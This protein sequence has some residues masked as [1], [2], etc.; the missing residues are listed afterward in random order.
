MKNK[1]FLHLSLFLLLPLTTHCMKRSHGQITTYSS[2]TALATPSIIK[3]TTI[4]ELQAKHDK[5]KEHLNLFY[6]PVNLHTNFTRA[7]SDLD[8][9]LCTY[10][11]DLHKRTCLDVLY[12]YLYCFARIPDENFFLNFNIDKLKKG[13]K[14]H[15]LTLKDACH[16]NYSVLGSATMAEE[17]TLQEKQEFIN[18]LLNDLGCDKPTAGDKELALVEQWG[19]WLPIIK[20]IYLFRCVPFFIEIPCADVT[21][22][23]EWLML[24]TEKSLF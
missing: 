24:E 12:N 13:P 14:Q 3:P 1:L 5:F 20:K 23:I 6:D 9:L 15:I 21:K 7:P 18:I 16:R 22:Y 10:K 2:S 8:L 11:Q 17:V 4:K 19:R